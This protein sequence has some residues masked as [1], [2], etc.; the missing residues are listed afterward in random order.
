MFY[1][2]AAVV[3]ST[4]NWRV[5]THVGR[6]WSGIEKVP[7]WSEDRGTDGA[8]A[9]PLPQ[10]IFDYLMSKWRIFV[11]TWGI[12]KRLFYR[13]ALQHKAVKVTWAPRAGSG[14]E[15]RPKTILVRLEGARTALVAMHATE[16][17]CFS[18]KFWLKLGISYAIE[19]LR[20]DWVN[21]L[22]NFS[23]VYFTEICL[24]SCRYFTWS[25][26]LSPQDSLLFKSVSQNFLNLLF[27]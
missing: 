21:L 1:C 18:N 25:I 11:Y 12:L 24:S 17:T 6:A 15:P 7:V 19:A 22:S 3:R 8:E 9:V 27:K 26:P 20:G 4:Y 2:V 13:S 10:K 16:M 14:A 5:T 23:T